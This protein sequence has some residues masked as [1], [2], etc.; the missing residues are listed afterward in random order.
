MLDPTRI[1]V[2]N[3]PNSPTGIVAFQLGNVDQTQ[4]VGFAL[5]FFADIP[6]TIYDGRLSFHPEL[7]LKRNSYNFKR[8]LYSDFGFNLNYYSAN[9]FARYKSLKRKNAVFIDF[10]F[11][12]SIIDASNSYYDN[13]FTDTRY[14]LDPKLGNS[15]YGLGIGAGMS[16]PFSTR[17]SVDVSLRYSYLYSQS[18]MP[19]VSNLDLV[20][21]I[22]F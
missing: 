12:Y 13:T 6:L 17:K 8:S 19:K 22:S 1:I 15:I 20:V 5:G 3:D 2:Y 10:G 18:K 4:K 11:I 21:G 9:L 16:F 14:L 7:E